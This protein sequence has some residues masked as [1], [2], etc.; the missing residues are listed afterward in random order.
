MIDLCSND[1]LPL[2]TIERGH[3]FEA[4]VVRFGGSTSEHN[5]FSI[6]SNQVGNL[7][8]CIFACLL[9]FPSE[10]VRA[11]MRVSKTFSQEW[12][13]FIE[14]SKMWKITNGIRIP[15]WDRLELLLNY[16]D[17]ED[18]SSGRLRDPW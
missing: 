18:D 11:G 1:V 10:T 3:A 5:F 2:V 4:K 14:N 15:T 7:L 13:H 12:K 9:C 8:A 6:C 16:Q 17:I